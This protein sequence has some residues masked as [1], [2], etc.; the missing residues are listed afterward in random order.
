MEELKAYMRENCVIFKTSYWSYNNAEQINVKWEYMFFLHLY[1]I[2][3][4]KNSVLEFSPKFE[5]LG[6]LNYPKNKVVQNSESQLYFNSSV[7]K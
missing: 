5:L 7:C 2:R 4:Q 1:L 3:I 6:N